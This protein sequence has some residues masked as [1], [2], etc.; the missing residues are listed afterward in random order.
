MKAKAELEES[1]AFPFKRRRP[2]QF[3]LKKVG[4]GR[5]REE[6]EARKREPVSC[7]QL[8]YDIRLS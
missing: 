4:E 7:K 3:T 2:D 5:S 6:G 1:G 8:A